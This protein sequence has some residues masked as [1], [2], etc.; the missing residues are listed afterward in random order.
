M[1]IILSLLFCCGLAI[2]LNA[3]HT[4]GF[5]LHSFLPSGELKKDSP[6]IWGGGFGVNAA[7]NLSNSPIYVGGMFDMTRYGSELRDG[8][9]GE[10]LGDVRYR[11][12][13]EMMRLMALIR[14]SPDCDAGFY[15]YTDFMAGVNYI[16]TRSILR[17]SALGE[18]FDHFVDWRD[19]SFTYG[20]TAGVEIPLNETVLLDLFFRTLK[21]NRT[22]YLTPNSTTYD[23][24]TESYLLEVRQSRFDS[25][26][27]GIGLKFYID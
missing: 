13:N 17:E 10:A 1:K 7:Y 16:Y 6:A 18:A 21:S 22:K 3:Q 27:F 26:S 15:P 11:R 4:A 20:L 19:F 9:H 8:W 12:H 2:S 23:R 14:F 5:Q 25:F 24:Q